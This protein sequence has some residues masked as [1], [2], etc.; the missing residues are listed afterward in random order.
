MAA[1]PAR[2]LDTQVRERA[3]LHGPD[4]LVKIYRPNRGD[5]AVGVWRECFHWQRIGHRH[6]DRPSGLGRLQPEHRVLHHDRRLGV[7]HRPAR[8]GRISSQ[9]REHL[10]VY[11]RRRLATGDMRGRYDEPLV[12]KDVREARRAQVVRD[13]LR[14]AT[15]ADTH[16]NTRL[17]RHGREL[18]HACEGVHAASG[19]LLVK[20]NL[21][22]VDAPRHLCYVPLAS[23]VVHVGVVLD[24][25]L[26][27][28]A[29]ERHKVARILARYVDSRCDAHCVGE[30]E[31]R[32]ALRVDQ[33]AVAI[34]D[35][36]T[37]EGATARRGHR[38]LGGAG[39]ATLSGPGVPAP[40]GGGGARVRPAVVLL[41]ELGLECPLM[42]NALGTPAG[43]RVRVRVVEV[44]PE[45]DT[46][47]LEDA[48]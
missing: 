4:G 46:L 31:A 3:C 40:A 23:L 18:T 26:H 11:V 28:A 24:R 21:E 17:M 25:R 14:R 33:H 47:T 30:R 8:R 44:S 36:R 19:A 10:H 38:H 12:G 16:G 27:V 41:D 5:H 1:R 29:E 42:P 35:E 34:E 43:A 2:A 7:I 9:S 20:L 13:F 48:T 32:V 39:D 6:R 15:R 45:S 37:V 22:L